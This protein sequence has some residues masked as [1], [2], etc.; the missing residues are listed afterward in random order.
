VANKNIVY[1]L[2]AGASVGTGVPAMA[3]FVDK[4][5]DLFSDE[6]DIDIQHVFRAISQLRKIYSNSHIDLANIE[7]V[8]AAFDMGRLVKQLGQYRG[9]QTE[10]LYSTLVRMIVKT[11]E[12]TTRFD[13]DNHSSRVEGAY[14][15]L[16]DLALKRAAATDSRCDFVTLNYDV[17][18]DYC[19]SKDG[20]EVDYGF[21]DHGN[22]PSLLK[23]H[24]SANWL[25]YDETIKPIPVS[26]LKII[27]SGQRNI[28]SYHTEQNRTNVL[29]EI[30]FSE[31]REGG[32]TF[33]VPPSYS[34]QFALPQIESVWRNAA[35]LLSQADTIV[36]I[37]YSV[38]PSDLMFHYLFGLGTLEND[39][40]NRV[41]CLDPNPAVRS[42]YEKFL[43]QFTTPRLTF[44]ENK[45]DPTGLLKL[46]G[47]INAR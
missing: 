43:G 41:V 15:Q 3:S 26:L 9:L 35:T 7:S 22:G 10:D 29:K 4:M 1:I 23:L 34:K 39:R 46:E 27:S 31:S 18:L 37:G 6:V 8:L 19:L 44:L 13:G 36:F 32:E 45:F 11:V 5:Y 21:D 20:E 30:H 2:G 14:H 17:A 42:T 40:I 47:I 38:P 12:K 16:V 25:R 33:I 28:L 24:G